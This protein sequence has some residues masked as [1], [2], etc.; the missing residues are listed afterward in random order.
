MRRRD[1]RL[2]LARARNHK[3][4][5]AHDQPRRRN[6]EREISCLR[7]RAA[8]DDTDN[9]DR[10][11]HDD[12]DDDAQHRDDTVLEQ[13]ESLGADERDHRQRA[14]QRVED[15]RSQVRRERD[16]GQRHHTAENA[17]R[18]DDR[19][20][21][22]HDDDADVWRRVFV[23]QQA[24][25]VRHF[26]VLRHGETDANAGVHRRQR[27]AKNCDGDRCRDDKHERETIAAEKR[28]AKLN[29]HVAN[30]RG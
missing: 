30:R 17:N 24:H 8:G 15:E 19:G 12:V 3:V 22:D 26:G 27:R 1:N 14:D 23:V 16:A 11:Q 2:A 6:A 5:H 13:A 21:D 20:D 7:G 29:R 10:Q 18:A 4:Q 28:I 25:N 9:K